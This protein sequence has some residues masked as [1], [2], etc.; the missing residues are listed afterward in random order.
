MK[1]ELSYGD[2]CFIAE[3]QNHIR[4]KA[5]KKKEILNQIEQLLGEIGFL[6]ADIDNYRYCIRKKLG[7]E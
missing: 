5:I 3:K 6:D 2:I 7:R 1:A 4:K